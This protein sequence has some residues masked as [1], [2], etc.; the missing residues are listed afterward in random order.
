MQREIVMDV[1]FTI[2][3]DK[4]FD[5]LTKDEKVVALINRVGSLIHDWD[6]DAIGFVDQ[7]ENYSDDELFN[8][9]ALDEED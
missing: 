2:E 3:T 9:Y 7:T 8:V 1:A 5:Q 6:E 4:E